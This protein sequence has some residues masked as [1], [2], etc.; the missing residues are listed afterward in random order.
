MKK[1]IFVLLSAVLCAGLWAQAPKAVGTD[2]ERKAVHYIDGETNYVN[3]DVFFELNSVDRETGLENVQFAL[4]NADFMFYENPFQILTEGK[5]DI[6]YRGF[7]NSANLEVAKTFSV[8]VDNTAPKTILETDK[9]VYTNGLVQYCSAQTKWFVTAKD[10]VL[11]SGV[12]SGYIGSDLS[13]L[14]AYGKS[15]DG[16]MAYYTLSEEGPANVYYTAI[17]NVG[18]L[19]PIRMYAVVVDTTAPTVAIENNNR[20]INK[21]G[22]YTV[23]PSEK[24]VDEE[25]RIIVSTNEAVSFS[26]KDEL[27]GVDAI[28]IKINDGEYTKYVEPIAFNTDTVY[29]IEVKAIDNVGNVSESVQYTFYVDKINPSSTLKVIDRAGNALKAVGAADDE[30]AQMDSMST[31]NTM[32]DS[33]MDGTSSSMEMDNSSMSDNTDDTAVQNIAQ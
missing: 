27:S 32:S 7:D 20:L 6:S 8:I 18:N 16:E 4:D 26:A 23:F 28:Y 19:A 9:P 25:G 30:E 2:Y 13:R 10:N 14:D 24:L 29:N 31:M 11:G 22:D 17:D 15:M 1:E 33:S 3:S 12:A 5:H 21:E